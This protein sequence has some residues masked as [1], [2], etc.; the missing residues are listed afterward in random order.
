MQDALL[1]IVQHITSYPDEVKVEE[2]DENGVKL[3]T[4]SAHPDDIGRIIG[5]DGK[6]IKAIRSIMRVIAI[7]KGEH[8]RVSVL[9][10]LDNTPKQEQEKE[11]EVSV[12]EESTVQEEVSQTDLRPD[13]PNQEE[14]SPNSLNLDL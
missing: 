2:K 12:A 10:D 3:F 9:S 13:L 11:G 4:I 7:Q 14:D 6:I 1:Y 8:V 5:K